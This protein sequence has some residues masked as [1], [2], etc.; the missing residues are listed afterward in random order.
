VEDH[1]FL[2]PRFVGKRFDNHSLPLEILKDLAVLEELIIEVAKRE[3]IKKNG[4]PYL[5]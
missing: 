4:V 5:L 3:Y 1:V 2:K